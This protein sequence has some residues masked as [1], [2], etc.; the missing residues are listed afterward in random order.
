MVQ[1]R[2]LEVVGL[3]D[4]VDDEDTRK[5]AKGMLEVAPNFDH[6]ALWWVPV[7][8]IEAVVINKNA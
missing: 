2:R 1:L 3:V 7:E 8:S 6:A 4:R 5:L